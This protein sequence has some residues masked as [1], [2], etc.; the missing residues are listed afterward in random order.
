MGAIAGIVI[1]IIILLVI[2]AIIVFT[3][4]VYIIIINNNNNNKGDCTCNYCEFL[5]IIDSVMS[6]VII[7]SDHSKKDIPITTNEAYQIINRQP[8]LQDNIAYEPIKM[9]K[10]DTSRVYETV[11]INN[12]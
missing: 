12:K 6:L 10:Q 4:I 1:A 8:V 9:N 7:V 3:V 2:I 11:N 5:S